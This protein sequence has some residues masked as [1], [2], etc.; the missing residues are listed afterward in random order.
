MMIICKRDTVGLTRTEWSKRCIGQVG[1]E[2]WDM[3]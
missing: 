3:V 1:Q 2:D